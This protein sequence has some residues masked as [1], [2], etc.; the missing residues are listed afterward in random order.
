MVDTLQIETERQPLLLSLALPRAAGCFEQILE[1][2]TLRLETQATG[3]DLGQIQ[4]IIQQFQQILAGLIDQFQTIA[5]LAVWG[6]FMQHHSRHAQHAIERGSDLVPHIGKKFG[7][8]PICGFSTLQ[9]LPQG[10]VFL[11]QGICALGGGLSDQGTEKDN[12]HGRHNG[13]NHQRQQHKIC[14][15]L[16]LGPAIIRR[17]FQHQAIE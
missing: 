11:L 2:E 1:V 17:P 4:H 13:R 8:G 10:F 12:P 9:S 5:R 16:K 3:L 7:L 14:I 6:A 15:I